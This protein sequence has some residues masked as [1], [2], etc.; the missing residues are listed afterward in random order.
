MFK[1]IRFKNFLSYGDQFCE[2]ELDRSPTT[3][4]TGENG[5]GKSVLLDALTFVLYN[6]PFRKINKGQLVNSINNK[7]SIVEIE[8]ETN[9]KCYLVRRGQKPNIFAIFE[10]TSTDDIESHLVPQDAKSADY[11]NKL[12]N[13]ILKMNYQAFTQIVILGKATFV[14]FMR[15]TTADRRQVIEDLLGLRIFGVMNKLLKEKA[16]TLKSRLVSLESNLE[17]CTDKI[18]NRQRYIDDMSRDRVGQINE[19][20]TR[21]DDL[22]VALNKANSQETRLSDK[23]VELE[24]EVVGKKDLSTSLRSLEKMS[25]KLTAKIDS[26]RD[27]IDFFDNNDDCPTCTQPIP[28]EYKTPIIEGR[29]EKIDKLNVGVEKLDVDI[30]VVEDK[31]EVI[32]GITAKI[33]KISRAVG[34]LSSTQSQQARQIKELGSTIST[35]ENVSTDKEQK[36]VDNLKDD[37]EELRTNRNELLET[38]AYFLNIGVML[39]DDGIK[40]LIINKY[41]PVFNQLINTYL[42]KMGLIIKFT[43]DDQF[44]EVILSRHRDKF[45]YNNFSEGQKLRIDLAILMSWREVAKM[46]NSLST[47]L[48]IMDEVLDSSLD[49]EGVDAFMD[50]IPSLGDSNVFVISHTPEKLYDKF[51]S[52]IGF[53]MVKNFSTMTATPAP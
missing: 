50:I 51:R 53:T 7:N 41:L 40:T 38:N 29:Y 30:E 39:K 43:L 45:S 32:N 31:L 10:H 49:Q 47:N 16:K 36:I 22:T 28:A 33:N 35:L 1:K 25:T 13:D 27:I 9:G 5:A 19:A 23:M 21:V 24:G 48:L 2:V 6:K 20:R 4:L 37:L 17:M 14:P 52:H 11:Q 44:N 8:F 26:H 15:L 12:E 3:L 42:Q 18:Q 46:K 34:E